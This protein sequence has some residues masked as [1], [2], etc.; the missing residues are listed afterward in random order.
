M[1]LGEVASEYQRVG[2]LKFASAFWLRAAYEAYEDEEESEVPVDVWKYLVASYLFESTELLWKFSS[3]LIQDKDVAYLS[4]VKTAPDCPFS[5][6]LGCRPAFSFRVSN[7]V[8]FQLILAQGLWSRTESTSKTHLRTTSMD[9]ASTAS[10]QLPSVS[11]PTK[12]EAAALLPDELQS[13]QIQ[14]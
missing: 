10:G 1:K 4:L 12:M 6:R 14:A 13:H 11:S 7:N 2:K 9:C 8:E 5:F 3:M